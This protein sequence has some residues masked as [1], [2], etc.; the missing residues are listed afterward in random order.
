M[1]KGKRYDDEPKLNIKKVIATIVAIIVLVMFV[2]SIKNLLTKTPKTKDVSTVDTYFPV[3]TNQK[4]GVIDNNG[5]II[6]DT[7][8]DEMVVVPDKNTDLFIC[9]QVTDYV[10]ETY[11]TKVI[12]KS[13]EEVLTNYDN[14]QAIE[15]SDENNVWYEGDVLKFKKDEKYG[16]IDF[17]GKIILNPEYDQI[18]SLEGI[19]K[20]LIIEK[21]GKKGLVNTS[22]GEVIILPNYDEITTLTENYE[23]GYIVGRDGKFGIVS[24]DAKIIFEPVYEEVKK[25]TSDGC[26]A[27][28]QNGKLQIIDNKGNVLL[29]SNFEDIKEIDGDNVIITSNGLFGIVKTSGTNVIEPQYEDLKYVY[30][31]YYIAKKNGQYGVISTTG[32]ILIDFSYKS[33]DYIKAADFI[34]AENESYTT[35]IINRKFETV[36]NDVI[37]SELNLDDG[38]IRVREGNNY[39]YYNFNFEKKTTQEALPTNTL[40]LVKENGKYGYENKNGERIVDAIYDDAKEQNRYGYCAVKK[41]GVWGALKSD[42]TVVVSPSVNLDENL[43]IDFIGDWYLMKD[44]NL[45]VYTK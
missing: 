44:L 25:V 26:Y 31:T 41:D 4:W 21:D 14:V 6:V 18:Y 33:M 28:R 34:Q 42:G 8:Y 45:N 29:D 13:G 16:L 35:D 24:A 17:S 9:T 10:A 27:V 30:G 36:L 20:N 11:S 1:G 40:F 37:I 12:N 38:Y 15:N 3:Y 19:Q 39:N 32:D 5:Q 2:I 7:I 43:Y 23:N 22:M